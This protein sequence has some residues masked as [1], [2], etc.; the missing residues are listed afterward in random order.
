MDITYKLEFYS[1]WH[2]GSGLSAGADVDLL[3]VKE[4]NNL[5]YV[6]GKTIKGLIREAAEEIML[7]KGAEYCTK[8]NQIFGCSE[9]KDQTEQ[10]CCF[11][12]NATLPAF[13]KEEIIHNDLAQHLY[14]AQSSTAI[15]ESGLAIEFSLRRIETTIPCSLTGQI[16]NVPDDFSNEMEEAL[17]FIKRLGHKRNRGLGRCQFTLIEKG[18]EL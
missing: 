13:L 2:C 4:K 6:P 9:N 8:I 17:S 16:L 5:P 18:G 3:V 12:T 7:L 10:G 14:R 1:D 15:D 11:F